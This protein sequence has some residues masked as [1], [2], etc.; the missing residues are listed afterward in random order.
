M[1]PRRQVSE[2]PS[3]LN[4]TSVFRLSG[5]SLRIS[6][7]S[8]PT[9][10]CRFR[11]L[12]QLRTSPAPRAVFQCQRKYATNDSKRKQKPQ[13]SDN[14]KDDDASIAKD[15]SKQQGPNKAPPGFEHL[16][17]RPSLSTPGAKDESTGP[18][19]KLPDGFVWL[20]PVHVQFLEFMLKRMETALPS[21]WYEEPRWLVSGMKRLGVP[22]EMRDLLD[23]YIEKFKFKEIAVGKKPKGEVPEV[24]MSFMETFRVLSRLRS[25]SVKMVERIVT[26]EKAQ[27][28]ADGNA[29]KKGFG[30]QAGQ[31]RS[32]RDR[33]PEMPNINFKEFFKMDL[34]S[35][36]TVALLLWVANKFVF[37]SE[38][39]KEITWQEFQ[40]SFLDKGL[41]EKLVVTNHSH[42]KVHL[43]RE[44][45]AQLYPES[46]AVHP[47][48]FYYFTIGSVEAFERRLDDAQKQLDI[49]A[50]ERLPVSY[51]SEVSWFSTAMSIGPTILLISFLVWMSRRRRRAA[52][53]RRGRI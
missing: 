43:H 45:V 19:P 28:A 10:L 1:S 34:S 31:E 15:A 4:M 17:N 11:S 50:S 18:T 24:E 22:R 38:N 13:K 51:T 30:E 36:L 39:R 33:S 41:V 37:P 12:Q 32:K 27:K 3:K 52:T 8:S 35:L 6:S 26:E 49:P 42:V 48:F 53:A 14:D 20:E 7:S 25:S 16:Y 44:A 46:P 2:P 23:E 5:S 47:N 40:N 29:G 9:P 21:S